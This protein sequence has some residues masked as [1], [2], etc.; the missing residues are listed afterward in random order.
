MIRLEY[1]TAEDFEQLIEW[2]TGTSSAFL[3]QWAGPTFTYPLTKKQLVSYLEDSNQQDA[4]NLIYKVIDVESD[5]TIGHISLG[6]ID[7]TNK[8]ARIGK[9]LVGDTSMRGKGIGELMIKAIVKVGFGDLHLHR[10]SLG[11][12]DFNKSAISCY[13]KVGFQIEGL[14]RDYRKINDQYWSIYE[15]SIL[16]EEWHVNK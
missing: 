5:K 8:S 10:L 2:N 14:L 6:K 9:V 11:V 13:K 3:L 16:E 4:T 1:F 15:M 12:F 7:Y